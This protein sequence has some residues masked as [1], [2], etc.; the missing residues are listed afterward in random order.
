MKIAYLIS[1]Y[2]D[3]QQLKRLIISLNYKNK[4]TFFIHV[5]KKV[6]IEPF[7]HELKLQN[8]VYFVKNRK[9]VYWGGYSQVQSII[10]MIELMLST[11]EKYD[12][13][14][15][16]TG[17][18]YPIYSNEKIQKKFNSDEQFMTAINVTNCNIKKQTKKITRYWF[19]DHKIENKTM[20]KIISKLENVIFCLLPF[21]KKTKIKVN[22]NNNK[23][24]D[25][26]F[27]SDY[28][29]LTYQCVVDLYKEYTGNVNFQKYFK[30]SFAPSELFMSTM[31][32]NSKYSNKAKICDWKVYDDLP[33]LTALHYIYYGKCI[34]VLNE[35][36]YYTLIDSNK[37]FARKF[38]SGYSDKLIELLDKNRK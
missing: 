16:I 23:Y 29:A 36:D 3:P 8:N 18:D 37:M 27:S 28:W 22:D 24:Y 7:M 20:V 14:V 32:F 25:V 19:F 17:L 30:Y 21:R 10:A 26:Y 11:K 13:V 5:D 31:L 9:K 6:N 34:K 33:S 12:R 15:S 38:K 4:C 2:L 1:A 35:N